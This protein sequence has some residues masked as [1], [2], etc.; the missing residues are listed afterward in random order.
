MRSAWFARHA[1][2]ETNQL[3]ERLNARE[4]GALVRFSSFRVEVCKRWLVLSFPPQKAQNG[5]EQTRF[6]IS[7]HTAVKTS[8]SKWRTWVCAPVAV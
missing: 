6:S 1:H 2:L 3:G 8:T 7:N 4:I 5:G